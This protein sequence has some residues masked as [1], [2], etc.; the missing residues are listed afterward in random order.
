MIYSSDP[1]YLLVND[2]EIVTN[3]AGDLPIHLIFYSCK[4]P[5]IK[6]FELFVI[7]NESRWAKVK[8][9]ASYEA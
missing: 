3:G 6:E 9:K 7:K 8:I 1:R 5:G 2:P 4:E